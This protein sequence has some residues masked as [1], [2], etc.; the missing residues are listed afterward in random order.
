MEFY[1]S[2]QG[3][4]RSQLTES[5]LYMGTGFFFCSGIDADM[6]NRDVSV[7]DASLVSFMPS[8][9]CASRELVHEFRHRTLLLVKALI[10]QRKVSLLA[11]LLSSPNLATLDIILWTSGRAVMYISI[12]PN[13]TYTRYISP[14]F[15]RAGSHRL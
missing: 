10:L 9:H 11:A 1:E 13:F 12:F 15:R 14:I 6:P 5:G 7:S 3:S 2:L 8:P 4:L